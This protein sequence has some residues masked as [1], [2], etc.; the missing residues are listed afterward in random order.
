MATVRDGVKLGCGWL[1]L[2]STLGC[3]GS[4]ATL[5]F[6]LFVVAAGDDDGD[7]KG[8]SVAQPAEATEDSGHAR[9]PAAAGSVTFASR[10]RVRAKPSSD[11]P[12]IAAATADR[13]YPIL[14]RTGRW[15]RIRVRN[16]KEGWSGCKTQ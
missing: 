12:V 16:G 7:E 10:C 5:A 14:E 2:K 15:Y 3:L 8:A 9:D 4:V 11:A 6:V 1:V 13:A